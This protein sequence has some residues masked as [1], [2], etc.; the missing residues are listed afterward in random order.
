MA[1]TVSKLSISAE[2]ARQA[3]AG[4][5]AKAGE[6]GIAVATAVLDESGVL[7]AFSRMDGAPVISVEIAKTKA[8]TSTLGMASDQLFEYIKDDPSMMAGVPTLP[9][10]TVVGGGVP[11]LEGATPVGAI[12]VSGGTWQ[13]DKECAEAGVAATG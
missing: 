13:Q 7:K 10:L 6:L 1:S 9:G 8:F 12:G 11:V 2:A 5:E 3:I 4:A